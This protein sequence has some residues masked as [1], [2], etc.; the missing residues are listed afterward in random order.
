MK[1]W[2]LL[3]ILLGVVTSVAQAIPDPSAWYCIL[4][5]YDFEIRTDEQ[6]NQ[7]GVCVF[8]DGSVCGTWD[9]YCKCEPN[10]IGCWLGDFSCHWPCEEMRCKE[11]G[12]SVLV[13]QCCEGLDEIYPAY[14]FD[15][16]CNNLGMSGWLSL[17]SDCGNGFCESWESRCNCPEDCAQPCIIYVDADANGLNDGSS[18]T[19]AFNDLQ[20]A[21]SVALPGD[22]IR[23]AQGTY[24]PTPLPP[25]KASNP[26]PADG[27]TDVCITADLSWTAGAGAVSHDVYFGTTSPGMFQ[28][29]QTNTT[30]DPGTMASDIKYYW[31][32]D[33]VDSWS[34]STGVV[35][36]FTTIQVPPMLALSPL[37]ANS[38]ED[39]TISPHSRLATF[40]LKN[41]IIIKGGYAGFGEPDPDA[42]YIEVYETILSGDLAGNDRDVND[43]YDL[44]SDPCRADNCY[45][46]VTA[47]E[48]GYYGKGPYTTLDGF[49]ITGGN[50]DGQ[51][52]NNELGK[53]GGMYNR[54]RSPTVV[55]CTFSENSARYSGGG[56]YN[57]LS[58]PILTNCTF[59]ENSAVFGGGMYNYSLSS[60]KLSNCI[61]SGN[62]ASNVGAGMFNLWCSSTLTNCTFSGNWAV[63][64]ST[65]FNDESSLTLNNCILWDEGDEIG[66]YD[67][68]TIIVTYSD[69]QGGWPG[70]GNLDADPCFVDSDNSDYHLLPGSPC[71]DAGDPN[72]I[73]E[74]NE[75]DLDGNPRIINS[76][77][78]MGAYEYIPPIPSDVDIE[79]DTLNLASKGKWISAFI[80]LPEDYNVAD[81]DPKS[82]YLDGEIEPEQ[83]RLSEDNQVAIA[84]FSR[85]K[86]QVILDIGEV[87]LTITGNFIDGIPFEG[88]DTIKVIN[89]GGGKKK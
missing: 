21:L 6:G 2:I 25:E 61:F 48:A 77:I 78:D 13:S 20:G 66:I 73:A 18:W 83:F 43:P 35:R 60:P 87:E 70:E 30:F 59:S 19:D 8:P 68:L 29:N 55:N 5:G 28:G 34:T 7:Y 24:K 75:T 88:T 47:I 82:V 71:I 63:Y 22:K 76:R 41:G 64:G 36:S 46:V 3:L 72:Y 14:I 12:E 52:P 9:Y 81:I 10:G 38:A 53:G 79:P 74:P 26:S 16:N 58:S 69:V 44:L 51:Y 17:C 65:V 45:H 33:E 86:V 80:W 50:A 54:Y 39:T 89:K 32:I 85:E 62:T 56:M 40:V 42:R 37:G 84:K 4:Q 1:E 57:Y 23:V 27:S 67:G 49:T 31:R 15:A 11:A